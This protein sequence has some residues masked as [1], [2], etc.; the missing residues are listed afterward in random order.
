MTISITRAIKKREGEGINGRSW[1][2]WNCG[3]DSFDDCGEDHFY[4]NEE[5]MKLGSVDHAKKH[6]KEGK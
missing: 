5:A 6:E 2:Y 3:G 4:L 1:Y